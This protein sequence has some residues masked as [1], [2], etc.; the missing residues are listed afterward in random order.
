[1]QAKNTVKRIITLSMIFVMLFASVIE[2]SAAT[3]YKKSIESK[4][5]PYTHCKG[6]AFKLGGTIR[7]TNK[8]ISNATVYIKNYNKKKVI[9]KKCLTINNK[10]LDLS[11]FN[12]SIKLS[13]LKP[14]TYYYVV[15]IKRGK[16]TKTVVS[17]KFKVTWAK[18][19]FLSDTYNGYVY[20]QFGWSH[21]TK[22]GCYVTSL[23]MI[24][25]NIKNKRITPD[26]MYVKLFGS[27]AYDYICRD[28]PSPETVAKKLGVNYSVRRGSF[29]YSDIKAEAKKRPAGVICYNGRHYF[30][31]R[32]KGAWGLYFND[33][34]YSINPLHAAR[35]DHIT[36]LDAVYPG[37]ATVTQMIV[38]Y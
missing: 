17:H 33:P 27:D 8:K 21:F 9:L 16:K 35:L 5:L 14:G 4:Y 25:S 37:N 3:D 15:N 22:Q 2:V 11:K 31:A 24:Y 38:F 34:G 29:S 12:D 1:M 26:D 32:C 36:S 18:S 23:A 6:D 10:K 28:M 30:V 7:S 19:V 20:S 13:K